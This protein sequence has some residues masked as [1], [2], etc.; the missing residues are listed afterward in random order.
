MLP[1]SSD[2]AGMLN[3]LRSKLDTYDRSL[4]EVSRNGARIFRRWRIW[5]ER[6]QSKKHYALVRA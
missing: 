4:Y 5:L 3:S 1:N 6:E 2:G